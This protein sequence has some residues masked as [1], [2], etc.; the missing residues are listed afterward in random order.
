MKNLHYMEDLYTSILMEKE[1]LTKK[2]DQILLEIRSYEENIE[3]KII[4]LRNSI[5]YIHSLADI[6][7]SINHTDLYKKFEANISYNSVDTEPEIEISIKG[8]ISHT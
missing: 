6:L 2:V 7:R 8:N 4:K 1:K 5:K 3:D